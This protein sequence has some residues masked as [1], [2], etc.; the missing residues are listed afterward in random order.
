MRAL[1]ALMLLTLAPTAAACPPDPVERHEL[2][3]G[4]GWASNP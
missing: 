3:P 4:M 1:I 2:L